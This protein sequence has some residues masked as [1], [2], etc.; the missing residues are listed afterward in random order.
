MCHFP[1]PSRASPFFLICPCFSLGNL[2]PSC[3]IGS[4]Q[5]F[6]VFGSNLRVDVGCCPWDRASGQ[7][8]LYLVLQKSIKQVRE[9]TSCLPISSFHPKKILVLYLMMGDDF[10]RPSKPRRN[11]YL[12]RAMSSCS[13][14]AGILPCHSSFPLG[15]FNSCTRRRQVISVSVRG[16]LAT[17]GR[18]SCFG[19]SLLRADSVPDGPFHVKHLFSIGALQSVSSL[20]G[21]RGRLMENHL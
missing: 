21:Y 9:T 5:N 19:P 16:P 10:P 13:S 18:L 7:L 8:L 17:I 11:C 1:G 20:T 6:G 3:E 2:S 15:F 4:G 14:V 12:E